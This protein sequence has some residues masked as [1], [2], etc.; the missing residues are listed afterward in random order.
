MA[1]F[2]GWLKSLSTRDKRGRKRH[3]TPPVVAYFWD[4]GQPVAHT[5]KDISSTGFYLHTSDRWLPG[6][7]IT[8]TLRRT[9]SDASHPECSVLV[10]SKVMRYGEDGVGFAFIPVDAAHSGQDSAGGLNAA[11]RKTL[12]H[13]IQLLREDAGYIRL[14]PALVLLLFAVVPTLSLEAVLCL[15]GA[16]L[17]WIAARATVPVQGGRRREKAISSAGGR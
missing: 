8:M 11:D 6:T 7:L 4:G 14:G 13:F 5:V 17:L 12:D 15:I 1:P 2:Q 3:E 10:V 9:Y 16:P